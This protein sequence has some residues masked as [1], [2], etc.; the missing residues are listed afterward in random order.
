MAAWQ[1]FGLYLVGAYLTSF[2]L[3]V[4]RK[5]H[6]ENW[7]DDPALFFGTIFWPMVSPV[8]VMILF[9]RFG[10]YL[11]KKITGESE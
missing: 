3:G 9:H 10:K 7:A 5:T 8:F 11:D 6:Y 4:F 2:L 1:T